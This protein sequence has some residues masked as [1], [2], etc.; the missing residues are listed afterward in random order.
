MMKLIYTA[1]P[2]KTNRKA[3]ALAKY[4]LSKGHVPVGPFLCFPIDTVKDNPL[5]YDL[6]ML[7]RCD[8]VW[9]FYGEDEGVIVEE[10][11]AEALNIPW[12]YIK[13]EIE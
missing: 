3:K 1:H 8:E 7:K 12:K 9:V 4:V 11:F 2:Y 6:E 5:V 13:E 10:M